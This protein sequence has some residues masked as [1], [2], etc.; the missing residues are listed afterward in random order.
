MTC[1]VQEHSTKKL[2]KKGLWLEDVTS[3]QDD[4]RDTW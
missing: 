4:L 1:H 3:F 2:D